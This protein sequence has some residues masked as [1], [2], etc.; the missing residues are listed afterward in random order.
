MSALSAPE[1][2]E[3]WEESL[4]QAPVERALVLLAAAVPGRT[5]EDL[6]RA[7][8]GE[9]DACLLTLRARTFGP[10]LVAL[11]ACPTCAARVEFALDVSDILVENAP[12]LLKSLDAQEGLSIH[13]GDYD[14]RFRAPTSLDL[15]EVRDQP[16]VA[17]ARRR[18]LEQCMLSVTCGGE[19]WD[20]AGSVGRLPPDVVDAVIAR[21]RDADPQ[22]DIELSLA[23]PSCH[24]E[25]QAGFDIAS[26][27]WIEIDAWARRTLREVHVLASA[28]GW[29][30]ADILAMS[31]SRRQCYLEMVGG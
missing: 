29:R 3:V 16:E 30:E 20:A 21:M 17:S 8:I 25:W 26:F 10:S 6:L 24:R 27:L 18:L 19:V 12:G 4:D 7:S 2:L 5:A 1:L 23:C 15:A 14:V 13:V 28:Y 31:P 9:R 22:G 11:A